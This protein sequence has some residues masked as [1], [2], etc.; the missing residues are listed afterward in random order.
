[1]ANP[2]HAFLIVLIQSLNVG[3]QIAKSRTVVEMFRSGIGLVANNL[4]GH[5]FY[6][7]IVDD[8]GFAGSQ[9][10]VLQGTNVACTITT[11]FKKCFVGLSQVVGSTVTNGITEHYH[12]LLKTG[13]GAIDS[14]KAN[15]RATIEN[16][17][18][19]VGSSSFLDP[20]RHFF[21]SLGDQISTI[22]TWSYPS[23]R[24]HFVWIDQG[25]GIVQNQY[26]S[27]T[28]TFKIRLGQT[29][30]T[31]TQFTNN[32]VRLV[33]YHFIEQ[34][35]GWFS[36]GTFNHN[37]LSTLINGK[38]PIPIPIPIPTVLRKVAFPYLVVLAFAIAQ[39]ANFT[40][41]VWIWNS[42]LKRL[43]IRIRKKVG[44]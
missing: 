37:D 9:I 25:I 27:D 40:P 32:A 13:I 21:E 42:E 44:I 29:I 10:G 33:P 39:V 5:H 2:Q 1:M 36:L 3:F 14:V 23:R 15:G 8:V 38:T 26:V 30:G 28:A 17:S 35:Q 22:L 16:L 12:I 34:L 7:S 20:Y 4:T 31:I 19:R 11:T 43:F 18:G 24:G 6:R 41:V